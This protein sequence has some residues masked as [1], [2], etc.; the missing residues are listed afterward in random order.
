MSLDDDTMVVHK[1]SNLLIYKYR[2]IGM[3]LGQ[4]ETPLSDLQS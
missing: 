2:K 4:N 1:M 3:Q